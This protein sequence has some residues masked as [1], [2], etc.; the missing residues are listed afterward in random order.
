[1]MLIKVACRYL[2]VLLCVSHIAPNSMQVL[3]QGYLMD[4]DGSVCSRSAVGCTLNLGIYR[5]VNTRRL[6]FSWNC[7][8]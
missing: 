4:F 5:K 2:G 8:V 3:K 1:M 6:N 7:D